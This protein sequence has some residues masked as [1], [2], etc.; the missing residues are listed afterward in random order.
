[1]PLHTAEHTERT[2]QSLEAR[3]ARVWPGL[4]TLDAFNRQ[5]GLSEVVGTCYSAPLAIGG[6]A[7][8]T[9]STTWAVIRQSWPMLVILALISILLST[10]PFVRFIQRQSGTAGWVQFNLQ[11]VVVAS[12]LLLIGPVAIWIDVFQ[13]AIL[14]AY[15]W[16]QR[17][18]PLDRWNT[19]RNRLFNIAASTLGL[20]GA[21]A[22]YWRMGGSIPLP[23]LDG[24]TALKAGLMLISAFVIQ[25][26]LNGVFYMLQLRLGVAL[27]VAG[28]AQQYLR[29]LAVSYL[30]LYSTAILMAAIARQIGI[31]AYL[32][33]L[34]G[35]FFISLLVR[36]WSLDA[37]RSFQR[38]RELAHLEQL[39]RTLLL[40]P[41]DVALLPDVLAQHVPSMIQYDQLVIQLSTGEMLV[42]DP[43]TA[44][45]PAAFWEWVVTAPR[46]EVYRPGDR[47]PWSDHP[48]TAGLI[49]VS[50]LSS[51]SGTPIGGIWMAQLYQ[52]DDP[53]A[54]LPTLQ[55]LAAQIAA[56]LHRVEEQARERELQQVEQELALAAQIQESF[57]PRTFPMLADW[58]IAATLRPARQTSGDFYDVLEL[59]E[60]RVG[61]LVADVTDKGTG[62]ALFM[63]LA[64]T[65]IRTYA[66]EHPH[67]PEAA[68]AAA[69]R[70]MLADADT[71]MF[72]TVFYAVLDP[73]TGVLI[74]ANA[75]HN[76]P[77]LFQRCSEQLPQRLSLTG[78]PLGI[79]PG[80]SWQ[81]QM[82][83][84]EPAA[85]LIMYTDGVTEAQD[86]HGAFF[87]E[88]R[89]YATIRQHCDRSALAI[90]DALLAAVDAFAHGASQSDDITLLALVHE[91]PES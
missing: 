83:T 71:S 60:G 16:R 20:L 47:L 43:P 89:L 76:P 87:E 77:L 78:I 21:L 22:L 48:A 91:P 64:R 67:A 9:A 32:S 24:A 56:A 55:T 52:F 73:A 70:R 17:P 44:M 61:L 4:T 62:A 28:N 90:I 54:L 33:C 11:P 63:A 59:P 5:R 53:A 39:G 18:Q 57:L 13:E 40:M 88:A 15:F 23:P 74:Y 81:Q 1:M 29:F 50:I 35:I 45:P 75:G 27:Q 12:G 84:L 36:H 37:E 10:V 79:D 86:A 82:V 8:L 34:A 14:A 72:V 49:V 85:R 3:A 58:Q 31:G 65:L 30:P 25:V 80:A 38:S 7:W 46:V 51:E 41:S 69:N 66:F 68:L 2:A 26:L 6:L 42:Q 19:V